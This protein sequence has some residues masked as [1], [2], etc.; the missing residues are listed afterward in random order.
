MEIRGVG[1]INP[2]EPNQPI[3]KTTISSS[4]NAIPP[5][6]SLKVSDEARFLEDEAFIKDVLA[7]IPDIDQD[8]INIVKKRLEDG[9]YNNKETIDALTEKLVKILGF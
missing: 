3:K 4:T 6:D 9:H 1:G 2:T 5:K 7:K 8:R